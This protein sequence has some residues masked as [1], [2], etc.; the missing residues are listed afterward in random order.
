VGRGVAAAVASGEAGA[1]I[2]RMK[3]LGIEGSGAS[4]PRTAAMSLET[5]TVLLF[6]PR[7]RSKAPGTPGDEALMASYAAGD[8]SA[9]ETLYDRYETPVYRFLLRSVQIQSIAEDLLQET[10]LT[11]IRSAHAYQPTAPF[12][13]WLFRIARSRLVDHWRARDPATMLSLEAP[14][15]GEAHEDGPSLGET[16]ADA[17]S[18]QP[19]QRAMAMAQAQALIDAIQA[20]PAPQREVMLLHI[21]GELT[22]AQIAEVV[23]VGFETAKSRLRYGLDRLRKVRQEWA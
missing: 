2:A 10:W 22:L 19:H 14:A 6:P 23:G 3:D 4:P 12:P 1:I 21:E 17:E 15:L 7:G 8:A 16:I 5:A 18:G 20:L 11:V 13:A 9:F